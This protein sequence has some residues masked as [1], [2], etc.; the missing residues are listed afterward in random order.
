MMS[1]TITKQQIN[2]SGPC[3]TIDLVVPSRQIR[4]WE[5]D[6]VQVIYTNVGDMARLQACFHACLPK[7]HEDVHRS[8]VSF[9]P[10]TNEFRGRQV[11]IEDRHILSDAEPTGVQE[12]E[13]R[14]R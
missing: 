3:F 1:N 10:P 12:M 8:L 7:V 4:N 6:D 11:Q 2:M 13:E 5:D 14:H 9:L